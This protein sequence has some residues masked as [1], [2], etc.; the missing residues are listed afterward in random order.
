MVDAVC[1]NKAS[2]D[3]GGVLV[4]D[5]ISGRRESY[6][7]GN[8]SIDDGFWPWWQDKVVCDKNRVVTNGGTS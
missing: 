8:L 5:D 1:G 2:F 4:E 7:I 6:E 3:G